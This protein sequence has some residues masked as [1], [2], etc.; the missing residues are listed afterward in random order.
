M[1]ESFSRS[2]KFAKMSYKLLWENKKLLVFPMVS[3]IA[4]ILI[5]VSFILPM[6]QSGMLDQWTEFMDEDGGSQGNATLY[7]TAFIFYF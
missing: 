3:A 5:T 6:W 2:W 4:G 1:F 7:V